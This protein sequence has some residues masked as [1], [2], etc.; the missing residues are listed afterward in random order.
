MTIVPPSTPTIAGRRPKTAAAARVK[1]PASG[2]PPLLLGEQPVRVVVDAH[3]DA[4]AA[5]LVDELRRVW[6]QRAVQTFVDE[7][8]L[9]CALRV[10]CR[11]RR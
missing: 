9:R 3:D 1:R 11:W 4:W 6:R 7:R 10:G 8:A 5:D 2:P